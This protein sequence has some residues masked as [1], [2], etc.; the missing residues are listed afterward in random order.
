MKAESHCSK[1]SDLSVKCDSFPNP[2]KEQR[3][4]KYQQISYVWW[5]RFKMQSSDPN[6]SNLWLSKGRQQIKE[7]KGAFFTSALCSGL[8][9]LGVYM[10]RVQMYITEWYNIFFVGDLDFGFWVPS[11]FCSRCCYYFIA[12]L[13]PT[14]ILGDEFVSTLQWNLAMWSLLSQS[15]NQ[16]WF[17]V[18]IFYFTLCCL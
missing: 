8:Q 12:T 18:C 1:D 16:V 5:S 2:S 7:E 11:R 9:V 13:C 15:S 14:R 17:T 3:E 6:I 10:L 4:R